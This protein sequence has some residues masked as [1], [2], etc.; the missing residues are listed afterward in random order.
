[1]NK[2]TFDQ[3]RIGKKFKTNTHITYQKTTMKKAKPILKID[4]SIISPQ[5]E[6]SVF[7]NTKIQLTQI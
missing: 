5:I 7:Y 2:V 1:M 4:G 6:T 3:I